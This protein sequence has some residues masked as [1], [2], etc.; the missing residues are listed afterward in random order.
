MIKN[1]V[2]Q[3]DE[4]FFGSD[5][6]PLSRSIRPA[7]SELFDEPDEDDEREFANPRSRRLPA[8]SLARELKRQHGIILSH[9]DNDLTDY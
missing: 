2:R 5:D 6:G 9:D 7:A 4:G 8:A 3:P 1:Q